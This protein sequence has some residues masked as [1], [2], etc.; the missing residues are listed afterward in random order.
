M[1]VEIDAAI[2]ETITSAADGAGIDRLMKNLGN[3]ASRRTLLRRLDGMVANGVIER[4]GRARAT[5]YH[6]TSA[7]PTAKRDDD[8]MILREDPPKTNAPS[9]TD[10]IRRPAAP[11]AYSS[12]GP[13]CEPCLC[14]ET[15]KLFHP[16]KARNELRH[17]ARLA[18]PTIARSPK[19]AAEPKPT[20]TPNMQIKC[21][22]S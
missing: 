22:F 19:V 10:C 17:P 1:S 15:R 12:P 6:A 13:K 18:K 9:K 7:T 11:N 20:K 3:S 8:R 2:R 16:A 14:T 5:R 21:P 4:R